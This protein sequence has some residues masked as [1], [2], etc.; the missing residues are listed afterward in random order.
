MAWVVGTPYVDV[1]YKD[2]KEKEMCFLY[3]RRGGQEKYQALGSPIFLNISLQLYLYEEICF[4][5]YE[6]IINLF[7]SILIST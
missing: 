2:L 1:R 5:L 4:H 7:N 6:G 3:D